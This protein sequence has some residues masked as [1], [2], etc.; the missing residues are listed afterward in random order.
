MFRDWKDRQNPAYVPVPPARLRHRV[1]GS[2]DKESFLQVGK[3]VA[4]NIRDLC[5]IVGRDIYSFEHILDFGC[6]CG[7]VV[8]NFQ[9]APTSCHLYGTDIDSDLVNWCKNNLQNIRWSTNGYRPP[10]PFENNTFDLIY[11]ISV[12]THLDEEFQHV[13]LRELQRIA[14]PGAIIILSVYGEYTIGMLDSSCQDEIHA[15]GFMFVTGVR[16]KLKLDGLPDFYQTTFHTQKY[17]YRKWS[18]YFDIDRYI[19]RGINN[20]QDAVLLRKT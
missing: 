19:E 10:L 8:R 6:G 12:F 17:I 13:W 3:I 14:K 15:H 4:Q 7:R 18:A 16:G 20:H 2:L 5:A 11:A 9:D 1:H